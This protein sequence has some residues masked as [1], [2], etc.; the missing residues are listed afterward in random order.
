MERVLR[1]KMPVV[2]THEIQCENMKNFMV[3]LII[4]KKNKIS[5]KSIKILKKM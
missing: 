4:I 5:S 3:V 1:A 2:Q